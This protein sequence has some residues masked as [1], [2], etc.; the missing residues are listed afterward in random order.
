ML[1]NNTNANK[2]TSK[3]AKIINSNLKDKI[4]TSPYLEAFTHKSYSN[5]NNL[6][7]SYERLEFLGDTILGYNITKYLFINYPEMDEGELTGLR[8][9][10]VRQETLAQASIIL[11]LPEHIY[12]GNGE[13][14]TGGHQR[15]SILSDIFESFLAAVYLDLGNRAVEKIL[16]LTIYRWIKE[17]KF[18]SIIDYK[19]K[20]QELIQISKKDPITYRLI[21]QIKTNNNNH[22]VVGVYLNNKE[23][24]RGEGTNKKQ[25]EQA[26]AKAALSKVI[27]SHDV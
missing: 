17:N 14:S 22:F 23:L 10:A 24:G 4:K 12:L 3:L 1:K 19:T 26:A 13:K 5:E 18:A 11:N 20:L 16:A 15:T 25:A 21:S 27:S 9:K 8:S 7:Y 6:S 2:I